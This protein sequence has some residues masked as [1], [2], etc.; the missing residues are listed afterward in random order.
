MT[1]QAPILTFQELD[2]ILRIIDSAPRD[3]EIKITVGD[4][5][6]EVATR[7]GTVASPSAVAPAPAVEA[8]I[9]APAPAPAAAPTAA[10][11]PA[12]ATPAPAPAA[13]EAEGELAGLAVVAA[14]MTGVFYAKPSPTADPFVQVGESV[15]EGQDLG[16]IEVMKLMNRITSPVAGVVRRINARNEDLVEHGSALF[17]IEASGGDS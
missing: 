17:Y 2:S 3:G 7:S 5:T 6:L 10:P 4:V 13:P 11:A 8:A 1:E 12:A 16:I 14:P 9:P 15:T